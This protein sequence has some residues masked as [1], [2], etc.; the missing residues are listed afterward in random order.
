MPDTV[1]GAPARKALARPC[2][3]KRV[4]PQLAESQTE[5]DAAGKTM[6][7]CHPKPASR[8]LVQAVQLATAAHGHIEMPQ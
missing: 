1:P 6:S 2:L 4:V 3:R 7:P 8:G 5:Q